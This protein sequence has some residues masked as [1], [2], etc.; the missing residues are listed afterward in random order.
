MNTPEKWTVSAALTL[1]QLGLI[2]ADFYQKNYS[3]IRLK[4][5]Y[6][7][8]EETNEINNTLSKTRGI[9]AGG[10]LRF[11]A[12]SLRGG[13]YLEESPYTAYKTS[14]YKRGLSSGIGFK[15]QNVK[16]D[17]AYQYTDYDDSYAIYHES[18]PINRASLRNK[19]NR[20]SGTLSFSF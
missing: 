7:F 20:I 8:P 9:K 2:S 14:H 15:F 10:E 11:K 19:T 6:E 5:T 17:V 3:L 4:D 1:G 18:E 12:V 16:F 13:G